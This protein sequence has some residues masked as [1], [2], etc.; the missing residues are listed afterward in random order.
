MRLLSRGSLMVTE[1][2]ISISVLA[3]KVSLNAAFLLLV[4][5]LM[6]LH[7]SNIDGKIRKETI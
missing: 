1:S 4:G 5:Q 7:E 3:R 6:F 2:R